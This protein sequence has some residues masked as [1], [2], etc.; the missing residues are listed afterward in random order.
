MLYSVLIVDDEKM[1][2]EILTHHLP[3]KE[4]GCGTIYQAEDGVEALKIVEEIH[5]EIIISDIKMPHMNGIALAEAVRE[6]QPECQFV[7]LSGYSDKEYLKSAIKLKAASYVEKPIDLEE[8]TQVLR[9]IQQDLDAKQPQDARTI[10]FRGSTENEEPLNQK[11]YQKNTAL[12][13][14]FQE[15]IVHNNPHSFYSTL[16]RVYNEIRNCEGTNPEEIRQFYCQILFLLLNAAEKRNITAITKQSDHLLYH[17]VK[18]ETLEQL[19]NTVKQLSQIYFDAITSDIPDPLHRVNQYVEKYYTNPDLTVQS[20]AQD[21]GFTNTYL[22]TAYKKSCGKTI[23]Q[24]ITEYRLEQAMILLRTTAQKLH[25]IA[26]S[27][28]YADGKY[29]TKIFTR[30][31]GITPR[32]YRERHQHEI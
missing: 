18:K 8:I 15:Y 16:V 9:S 31:T 3:W 11:V 14:E 26:N 17:T 25:K 27:V 24:Y 30:E 2:R 23:N 29:F 7:F 19:Q 1:P 4:L 21:L 22:C 10:F 28:G 5:P 6:I 20:M 13:E 32:Q 12:F